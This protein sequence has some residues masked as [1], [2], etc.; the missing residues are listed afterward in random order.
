MLAAVTALKAE[1]NDADLA[2]AGY[3]ARAY[4]KDESILNMEPPDCSEGVRTIAL[5]QEHA[6]RDTKEGLDK[7]MKLIEEFLSESSSSW[8]RDFLLIA[9]AFVAAGNGDFKG[10]AEAGEI[11]LEEVNYERLQKLQGDPALSYLRGKF[12]GSRFSSAI[13]HHLRRVCGSYYMDFATPNDFVTAAEYFNSMEDPK[14]RK[15]LLRQ[16]DSRMGI[17]ASEEAEGVAVNRPEDFS[18]AARTSPTNDLHPSQPGGASQSV[19]P[20]IG[21]ALGIL[22]AA[23]L[24][25]LK[26][27]GRQ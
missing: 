27:R 14:I 25:L 17:D 2:I 7:A 8:E 9:K 21:G 26:V 5:A 1:A 22:L 12:G 19:W 3:L 15:P 20:W 13:R 23:A 18:G 10:A 16:L 24:L 6:K 11:A 4:D